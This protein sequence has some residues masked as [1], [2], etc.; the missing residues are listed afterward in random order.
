MSVRDGDTVSGRTYLS[1]GDVLTLLRQ[2]F[3]DVTISKIRFL[4]SQGLV[5]PERTPSGYRKF[6]EHDVERLRWVLR[7]Q[8]EHFLPLKVI[9]GR[10]DERWPSST[11]TTSPSHRARPSPCSWAAPA[12]PAAPGRPGASSRDSSAQAVETARRGA[13]GGRPRRPGRHRRRRRDPAPG[14]PRPPPRPR[15]WPPRRRG[16]AGIAGPPDPAGRGRPVRRPR[17]GAGPPR[18]VAG[19]GGPGRAPAPG[20]RPG[21]GAGR[22]AAPAPAAT[23]SGRTATGATASAPPV[24]A[25]GAGATGPRR[26]RRS[27]ST[28]SWSS[29]LVG[30]TLS[31]ATHDHRGAGRR[32]AA[33][34]SPPSSSSSPT[35]C[36]CGR[37]VGGVAYYDEDALAVARVAAGLAPLRRRGAPPPPA[38][39]RRRA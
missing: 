13:D 8:R 9:K 15:R 39:A 24:S 12:A 23:V 19:G 4:E 10:L 17:S 3:P 27:R 37:V 35:G 38:Q 29:E 36:V 2:E 7:Q 22:G 31:G 6:Y 33:S 32:A 18:A 26:G 1:I 14:R 25:R 34:T 16:G 20:R 28:A 5:N 30:G 21:T 11:T